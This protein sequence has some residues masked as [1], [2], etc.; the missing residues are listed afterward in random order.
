MTQTILSERLAKARTQKGYTQQQIAEFLECN[1]AT[2]TNYENGKRT[3]DVD[4]IVKLAKLYE[5]SA[6]YL[7][8]LSDVKSND[9]DMDFVCNYTHLDEQAIIAL[10]NW[11]SDNIYKLI[12]SLLC[13]ESLWVL[14][15]LAILFSECE[16]EYK[17]FNDF[18]DNFIVNCDK[19]LSSEKKI[20]K[21]MEEEKQHK[22][23][24]YATKYEIQ[25]IV[26][27]L[28][29][30]YAQDVIDKN[31]ES[32]QKYNELWKHLTSFCPSNNHKG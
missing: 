3:P 9:K 21:L 7:L 2:V 29:Y 26:T 16:S 6:D 1:R 20:I 27:E 17:S 24:I 8:G 25:N 30:K 12:N 11:G 15:E 32:S 10:H 31:K 28:F 13:G 18:M 4:T 5:V 23:S 22:K 14:K 19:L